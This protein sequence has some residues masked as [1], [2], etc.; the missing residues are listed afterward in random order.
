MAIHVEIITLQKIALGYILSPS[1]S[2]IF[3]SFVVASCASCASVLA[4]NPVFAS[5][6]SDS[7]SGDIVGVRCLESFIVVPGIG[8]SVREREADVV[9]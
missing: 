6:C 2:V 7:E 9:L 5:W 1:L 4:T 3:C 8:V